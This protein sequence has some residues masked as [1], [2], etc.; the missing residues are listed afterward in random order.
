MRM[1]KDSSFV[2]TVLTVGAIAGG[3][4][5]LGAIFEAFGKPAALYKC[6][7][8]GFDKLKRDTCRCPSCEMSLDWSNVDNSG[9]IHE[10]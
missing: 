4:F 1:S 7:N 6:P 5:I 3:A 2:D 8:C 9:A 10:G